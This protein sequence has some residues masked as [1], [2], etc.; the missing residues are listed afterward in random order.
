[1]AIG[2]GEPLPSALRQW[3]E[4]CLGTD[5][6]PVRVHTGPRGGEAAAQLQ[7][8]AFT[9]GRDIA[10][11]P[12]EFSPDA[13]AG[14][15]LVAHELAHVVQQ[16]AAGPSIQRQPANPLPA[17]APPPAATA[18][19][20]TLAD[21]T[22]FS[23][24]PAAEPDPNL[25]AAMNLWGRYGPSV[26]IGQVQ[27][28]LLTSTASR[29]GENRLIGGRSF[30]EGAIPVIEVPQAALDDIAEY[31]AA[32]GSSGAAIGTIDQP[33]AEGVTLDTRVQFAAL[34]R[35]HEVVRLIGH[36]M[37]HLWR[38]KNA[39]ASN[40]IHPVYDA[41]ATRR[42][43][44][45]RAN[46]VQH[47]QNADPRTLRAH[48]IPPGTNIQ[49]WEDIPA[50]ERREI[51]RGASQTDHFEGLYQRSAYL[52][53]EIY[54][55]IEE[56]SYLRI[57]QGDSASGVSGPTRS[58]IG[59]LATNIY[60]LQ[61]VLHSVTDPA[62]LVTPALAA[63]TEREMLAYL[64]RRYPS[65]RGA[66]FDSYEVIFFL[67]ATQHG[68]APIYANGALISAPPNGARP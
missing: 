1:L 27:F 11:A 34:A 35:A 39:H 46:W 2:A 44:Q 6:S 61:N 20:G 63:Q 41:E 56:V 40:P 25:R 29:L 50:G 28:R 60:F 65:R 53:E 59:S 64:R 49:K 30:W 43:L 32:R 19:T 36:E 10:F 9:L 4:D 17:T 31:T 15:R 13:P 26:S 21:L 5:L 68:M 52:V 55:K 33:P 37:H 14:R 67:A 8:R 66:Q 7:A 51:E 24:R 54:T 57:Q 62:G 48:N 3:G 16:R 42:M 58:E 22:N 12:G 18:V 47:L 38:E 23:T 45:V